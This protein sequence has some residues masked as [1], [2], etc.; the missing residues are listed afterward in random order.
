MQLSTI[1]WLLLFSCGLFL[2]RKG[3]LLP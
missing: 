1:S 2:C 3:N